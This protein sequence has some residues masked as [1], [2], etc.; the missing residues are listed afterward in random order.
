MICYSRHCVR[1]I[2][3]LVFD[4]TKV[5][6]FALYHTNLS[7]KVPLS[8]V[9]LK[10]SSFGWD[11][12]MRRIR[13]DKTL[14][15]GIPKAPQ[16]NSRKI[17]ATKLGDGPEGNP[18]FVSNII[19]NLTWSYI[20]IHHMICVLLGASFYFVRIC[21]LLFRIMFFI[22]IFNK[23]VKDSL[24]HAYFATLHVAVSKH[25]VY[26]CCKNSLEKSKCDKMWKLFA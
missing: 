22:F 23:N 8:F 5:K 17:Q 15:L 12:D 4:S 21:F 26:R 18:S 1:T 9:W 10:F 2:M 19:R 3:N 24:Y 11:V 7:H 25:K 6:W 14:S 16:G 20:F 13:S